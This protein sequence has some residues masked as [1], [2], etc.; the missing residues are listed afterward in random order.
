MGKKL[1]NLE[2]PKTTKGR[3]MA[4]LDEAS[5]QHIAAERKRV[6]TQTGY[7]PGLTDALRML[8]ARGSRDTK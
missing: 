3:T 8:I 1:K 7:D 5:L 2:P 6:F 4:L